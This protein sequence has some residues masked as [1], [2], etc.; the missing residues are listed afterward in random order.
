METFTL[1]LPK[2]WSLTDDEF[3]DFC[4]ENDAVQMERSAHGEILIMSPTGGI[5][6]KRNKNVL[7]ELET[8]NRKY[9]LGETFDSSTGFKLPNGATRSPDACWV[10]QS[11][12]DSLSAEQQKKFPPLCPDFVVEII[13]ESDSLPATQQKMEEWIANG[14]RLGWLFQPDAEELFIYRPGQA[15]ERQQGFQQTVSG[16][17]V[18][19]DFTFDLRWL[20]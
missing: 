3:Y 12:W 2:Q 14:A 4:Q 9:Q 8:W 15:A 6:G 13:S 20:R 1:R 10:E 11:R 5:T 17:D 19:P 7:Y 18:L 16:E